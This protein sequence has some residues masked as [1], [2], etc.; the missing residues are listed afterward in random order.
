MLLGKLKKLK[1]YKKGQ[2]NWFMI[3]NKL[4]NS[5]RLKYLNLPTVHF[6]RCRGD[7][8]ETLK[9]IRKIYDEETAPKLTPSSIE[10]TRG[11]QRKLIKRM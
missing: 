9:I 7:V 11:Y 3:G 2:Q 5:D 6:R 1:K 8:I 10:Y 4:S